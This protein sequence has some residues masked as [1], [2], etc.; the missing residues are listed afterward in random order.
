MGTHAGGR[1]LVYG[2]I[3][4]LG[5]DK[6][7]WLWQQPIELIHNGLREE[8]GRIVR[9]EPD[10]EGGPRGRVSSECLGN[11]VSLLERVVRCIKHGLESQPRAG[12]VRVAR[13]RAGGVCCEIIMRGTRV[14]FGRVGDGVV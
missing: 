9:E 3:E 13:L 1:L 7:A 4:G 10:G 12:L 8:V 14:I 5:D 11:D 2:M 6:A